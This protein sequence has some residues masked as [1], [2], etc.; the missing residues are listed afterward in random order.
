M[1]EQMLQPGLMMDR[2][3]LISDVIE[4]GAGQFGEAQIVARETHGAMFRYNYAACR[5]RAKQLANALKSLGLS[6]GNAVGSVALNNHRH[7]EAYYA[8]SGSG[9]VLHTCNPRLHPQQLIYI[10]NHAEDRALLFDATYASLLENIAPHCPQ[11]RTWIC[12]SDAANMPSMGSL[13]DVLCYEELIAAHD[14]EFSWPQ[15]DERA[16][17]ALCYTSGTTGNPKGALYSHR[18]IVLN[19]LSACLPGLVSLSPRDTILPAVPM[20]HVNGW[21]IPYA[22]PIG[23][24]T[25]VL[26]GQRLDAPSLY[27]LLENEKVTVT[28]GVP[29]IWIA[30]MRHME[31]HDLRL[32]ALKRILVGGSAMPPSLIAKFDNQFGIEVRQAWGMT[33]TVAIA[34]MTTVDSRLAALPAAARHAVMAKQG[35]SVFGVELKVVD[36]S[37]RT[38][39]RDGQSQGEL[40]VRGLW[41][42]CGYYKAG[43]SALV[44]GW[45]PT[46]DIATIDAQGI[47]QIRDRAKDLIKTGGEWI[48]SIDL[49]NA[50]MSHPAVA[51]AAVIGVKHPRWEERPLLFIVRKVDQSLECEEI[52]AFLA[53][54]VAK[55]WLPEG[56]I[57]LES[58]PVG[59]TG[60]VQKAN[61]REK[62]GSEFG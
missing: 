47:M 19:A 26:P 22:A 52:L 34:T 59:G 39:P 16:A 61:L 14:D 18:S 28:A 4:H 13:N 36:E 12:L 42:I 40:M 44:D 53:E 46:G 21:C 55:W 41:T 8:V 9:M 17:A 51:M 1:D 38:L 15:F 7:L 58:L 32:P 50:A 29:T 37:G 56:V 5:S 60:K 10:I 33:E 30:L 27:E 35:K 6:A 23:G 49:E 2:Q 54:R 24:A 11:V 57:F 20:F 31:Q 3:L 45:L 48:S 25:L 62:Y 43:D